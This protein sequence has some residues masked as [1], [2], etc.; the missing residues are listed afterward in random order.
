MTCILDNFSLTCILDKL[1][2]QA[3]STSKKTGHILD[4]QKVSY[5][6]DNHTF[7]KQT[8]QAFSHSYSITLNHAYILD[9]L[10]IEKQNSARFPY[11]KQR[12]KI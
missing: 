11:T 7:Y 6:L 4:M 8:W 12:R 9:K 2:K 1:L 10:N 5:I 3:Y